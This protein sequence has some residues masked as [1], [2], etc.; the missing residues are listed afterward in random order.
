MFFPCE[1]SWTEPTVH[2]TLSPIVH[3]SAGMVSKHSWKHS[4]TFSSPNPKVFRKTPSNSM[5]S[6]VKAIRHYFIPA[7]ALSQLL[8]CCC[9]EIP[10]PRHFFFFKWE[11]LIGDLLSFRVVVHY[12]HSDEHGD[13]HSWCSRLSWRL[14]S[15][16]QGKRKQDTVLGIGFLSFKADPLVIQF[17]QQYRTS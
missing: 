3:A 12:Y 5:V 4:T 10:W 7:S 9:E 1:A 16:P 15:D 8:F 13:R 14:H 6:P 2:I 11:N 17:L